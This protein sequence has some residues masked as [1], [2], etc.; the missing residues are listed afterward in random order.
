MK[1]IMFEIMFLV[2]V[3]VIVFGIGF[4]VG[5]DFGTSNAKIE[6]KEVKVVETK[7]IKVPQNNTEAMDC[8][9]SPIV[10]EARTVDNETIMVRAHDNCK[11]TTAQITIEAQPDMQKVRTAGVIGFLGGAVFVSLI[12]LII[13]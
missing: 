11:E 7:F 6:I 1:K 12:L 10:I 9:M 8:A 5:Y 4:I 3:A 2:I 13:G